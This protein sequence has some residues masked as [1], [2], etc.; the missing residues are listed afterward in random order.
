VTAEKE[1]A[2]DKEWY[3]YLEAQTLR[4]QKRRAERPKEICLGDGEAECEKKQ[5]EK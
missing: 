5:L 1:A 2:K 4:Q 3:R